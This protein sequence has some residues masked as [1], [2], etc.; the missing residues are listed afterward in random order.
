MLE[1]A[2]MPFSVEPLSPGTPF[3]KI[4]RGLRAAHLQDAPVRARLRRHWIEDGVVAFCDGDTDEDFVVELSRVF[5]ELE[6]HP[7]KEARKEGRPE[8]ITIYSKPGD[9]TICEVD[10]ETGGGWLGWHTDL[11]Y[12]DKINHGGILRALKPSTYGGLTGFLDQATAYDTLPEALQARI[13]NLHVVYRMGD[14][15]QYRYGFKNALKILH[16]CP[17][18]QEI[19]DTTDNFPEAAHPM[20]FVQPDTGRKVLNIS[21][22]FALYV[23][24][25]QN[26]EGDALLKQLCDHINACPSY[27]HKWTG[28][29]MVLWDNWRML[30][31]VSPIPI[32]QER[33]MQRTTIK[34]DY[35]FGRIVG[36]PRAGGEVPA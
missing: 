26:P 20:V 15:H 13:E 30:H 32:D 19:W 17:R 34:G 2:E 27:H 22:F 9:V 6:N 24:E 25:M 7:I 21:P 5:G 8:L 14:W 28:D 31:C 10:G 18:Y 33:V 3:G 16:V 23:E 4:V 29:E 1:T 11:T 12:T 36:K 35:G